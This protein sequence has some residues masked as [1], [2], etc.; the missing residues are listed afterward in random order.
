ML[1][2]DCEYENYL[3]EELSSRNLSGEQKDKIS[4][5]FVRL[6]GD[7]LGYLKVLDRPAEEMRQ[8]FSSFVGA[9]LNE[10]LPPALPTASLPVSPV[11]QKTRHVDTRD[12]FSTPN[13]KSTVT[14]SPSSLSKKIALASPSAF[15]TTKAGIGLPFKSPSK[16]PICAQRNPVLKDWTSAWIGQSEL[17]PVAQMK[18]LLR[19]TGRVGREWDKSE[20]WTKRLFKRNFAPE[21][22]RYD[23][24]LGRWTF[25]A[26]Y[27][28]MLRGQQRI[29]KS[30]LTAVK[31]CSHIFQKRG[32]L[33][34]AK[35]VAIGQNRIEEDIDSIKAVLETNK[36]LEAKSFVVEALD[37]L[38]R[39]CRKPLAVDALVGGRDLGGVYTELTLGSA[40]KLTET[41]HE[42]NILQPGVLVQE[43][44]S[45]LGTMAC[46]L[47][48]LYQCFTV[49]VE[50]EPKRVRYGIQ[51]LRGIAGLWEET[52]MQNRLQKP[53]YQP[54]N[55][56][57]WEE[58]DRILAETK[59]DAQRRLQSLSSLVRMVMMDATDMSLEYV[60]CM[61]SMDEAYNDG[62]VVDL[63]DIWA[64]SPCPFMV[65]YKCNK[66][67]SLL[68][69]LMNR[70]PNV[71]VLNKVAVKKLDD[72]GQS[73]AV[74]L[75]KQSPP[76]PRKFEK[77]PC[78]DVAGMDM[79][80][81]ALLYPVT[82]EG[83][84]S[85]LWT[86]DYMA[87]VVEPRCNDREV[88]LRIKGD[89]E[90]ECLAKYYLRCD[91]ARPGRNCTCNATLSA[92]PDLATQIQPSKIEGYGL[93]SCVQI[94]AK[95]LI[96]SYNGV[97]SRRQPSDCTY[98]TRLQDGHYVDAKDCG[99]HAFINHSCDPNCQ[100]M[101][102]LDTS[103]NEATTQIAIL[104]LR[105]IGT[106]EEL[107][108]CYD[109]DP[110]GFGLETCLCGGSTC[111]FEQSRL[112]FFFNY[113][114]HP[115]LRTGMNNKERAEQVLQ[116][117][118]RGEITPQDGRDQYRIELLKQATGACAYAISTDNSMKKNL[119]PNF[120]LDCDVG[121]AAKLVAGLKKFGVRFTKVYLDWIWGPVPWW[122]SHVKPS[123]FHRSLPALALNALLAPGAEVFLP[124]NPFVMKQLLSPPSPTAKIRYDQTLAYCY[125]AE[126]LTESKSSLEG[127]ELWYT[128]ETCDH[129][130]FAR[131]FGKKIDESTKNY[132][133][134]SKETI[135][136]LLPNQNKEFCD[137]LD[138][139]ESVYGK[140]ET[141]RFVKL[142]WAPGARVFVFNM[143]V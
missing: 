17:P 137:R 128:T 59:V 103:D 119:D 124:F 42:M 108:I 121:Q 85:R 12:V 14:I 51:N 136:S 74:I 30:D 101:E 142:T 8:W 44:G 11:S 99:K 62:E 31:K 49:G 15:G 86:K 48:Y 63:M 53:E 123:L 18:Q 69:D 118:S 133:T 47:S 111:R 81:A 10:S 102:V 2:F 38:Y 73:T 130:K 21:H 117:A 127:H 29:N 45:G 36:R 96:T 93:F 76:T 26:E 109:T 138:K 115:L 28:K 94:A 89:I 43:N 34:L 41:L 7:D 13:P 9:Q 22:L 1:P 140:F 88:R 64:E 16:S 97:I 129:S 70:Y 105:N 107:T 80:T 40:T 113:T 19:A 92:L 112:L 134:Y 61:I 79:V 33:P 141:V 32:M 4:S 52:T 50:I 135:L 84:T 122:T 125:Q 57:G 68:R 110:Q 77:Y 116:L 139:L 91:P 143:L 39:Y 3:E 27:L 37:V 71:V 126:L 56:P 82:M 5:E 66:R 114:S 67:P 24:A 54:L 65:G 87:R 72:G 131:A 46:H 120:H 58:P 106:G 100:L 6:C 35:V 55:V 25:Q 23:P 98:A 95:Q 75:G 78:L 104:A 132:L 90:E 60:Q 83:W 20:Q